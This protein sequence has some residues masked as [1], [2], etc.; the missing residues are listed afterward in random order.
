MLNI[1]VTNIG[2]VN[3]F[4][5]HPAIKLPKMVDGF[6]TFQMLNM[7]DGT[8]FPL[9]LEP[10]ESFKVGLNLKDFGKEF[11]E[12]VKNN[13]KIRFQVIDSVGNKYL[14]KKVIFSELIKH[15][16]TEEMLLNENQT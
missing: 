3:T 9:K 1:H 12:K 10:G 4:I 16:K 15:F 5:N 14:S 7:Q 6:D 8:K 13:D 2:K 11:K